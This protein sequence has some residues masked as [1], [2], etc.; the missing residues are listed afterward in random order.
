MK[1]LIFL[2]VP[3]IAVGYYLYVQ[4]GVTSQKAQEIIAEIELVNDCDVPSN[5]FAVKKLGN[6][7]IYSLAKGSVSIDAVE[8]EKL[9]LVL[10]PKYKEVEY[11]GMI[12]KAA[13]FQRVTADCSFGEKQR[14]VTEGLNKTFSSG[15]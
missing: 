11:D 10:N 1:K 15:D 5:Y 6:G 2:A 3:L 14:G 8:G 12:F 7:R 13:P 4:I 9:Q